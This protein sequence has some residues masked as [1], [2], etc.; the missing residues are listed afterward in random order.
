VEE[1]EEKGGKEPR[2]DQRLGKNSC[3]LGFFGVV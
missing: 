3:A 2:R 1:E